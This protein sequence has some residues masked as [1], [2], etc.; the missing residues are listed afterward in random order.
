MLT[1]DDVRDGAER[2]EARCRG[3]A[4]E[5]AVIREADDPLLYL[6]RRAYLCALDDAAFG[7]LLRLGGGTTE[8][9]EGT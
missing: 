2:P 5:R 7:L 3:L 6:E 8:K 9:A 1:I 4:K